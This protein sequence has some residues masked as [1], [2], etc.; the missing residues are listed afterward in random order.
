MPFYF[1]TLDELEPYK[2]LIVI[3]EI[4]YSNNVCIVLCHGIIVILLNIL[5]ALSSAFQSLI[6][7]LTRNTSTKL[8]RM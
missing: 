2:G 5:N 1:D 3:F 4:H 6:R 7:G 8:W